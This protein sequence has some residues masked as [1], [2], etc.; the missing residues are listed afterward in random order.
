MSTPASYFHDQY[1]GASDP[2]HLAERWYDRRKYLLTTAA[3]PC[4]R[5]ARAF[6]PGCSVG[7]LSQMLAQRCDSL[8]STDRIAA[9][10]EATRRR[11]AGL[12][13][14]HVQQMTVPQQWPQSTFDL[15]VLSEILYYFDTGARDRILRQS[16]QSLDDGGHLVTV[17]WNHPVAEHSCTGRDIAKQLDTMTDLKA[18]A[19]YDDPDFTLTVHVRGPASHTPMSPARAEGLA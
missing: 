15:V 7:V 8:L 16:A 1:A 19:R 11:T 17:H 10:V 2:W 4:R 6:E 13:H 14:V 3:L 12:E 5:Y 9:A 18:L